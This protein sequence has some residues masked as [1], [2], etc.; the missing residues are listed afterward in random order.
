MNRFNPNQQI[1]K[2]DRFIEVEGFLADELSFVAKAISKDK[3]RFDMMHML[4]EPSE[5]P[6]DRK[7]KTS[8]RLR[9][10]ATDGRRLHL[11]DPLPDA[12][13][14][15]YGMTVGAWRVIKT[16]KVTQI[17]SFEEP[18]GD[19]PKYRGLIPTDP[20]QSFQFTGIDLKRGRGFAEL[21]SLFRK[22]PEPTACNFNFLEDL[23]FGYSW[24][25]EWRGPTKALTFKNG[26][27]LALVMP[28]NAQE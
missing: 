6:D 19:F 13:V 12:L 24:D 28:M 18:P 10:V 8:P 26:N 14:D 21:L 7:D 17:A 20:V 5:A 11:V 22:F 16:G 2:M 15:V 25:V 1:K 4:V 3:T 27:R 23:G 9:A